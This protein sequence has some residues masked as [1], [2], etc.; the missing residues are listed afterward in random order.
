VILNILVGVAILVTV[1]VTIWSVGLW[2]RR[3]IGPQ[4]RPLLKAEIVQAITD[5]LLDGQ[6][7]AAIQ[8]FQEQTGAG[9][10]E[11][12]EVIEGMERALDE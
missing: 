3:L 11:A 10:K 2:L 7:D 6:K 4:S 5:L 12:R 8:V 1:I 9:L